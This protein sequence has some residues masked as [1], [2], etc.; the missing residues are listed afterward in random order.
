[1]VRTRVSVWS[2]RGRTI[3]ARSLCYIYGAIKVKAGFFLAGRYRA[4]FDGDT[5]YFIEE[6]LSLSDG[7]IMKATYR[8]QE[9]YQG[10]IGPIYLV[11][12]AVI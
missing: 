10:E 11:L 12:E 5:D 7:V 8:W 2:E 6:A 3:N 1:M 4:Y 9:S